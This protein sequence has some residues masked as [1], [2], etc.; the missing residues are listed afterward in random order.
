MNALLAWILLHRPDLEVDLVQ[1]KMNSG[2]HYYLLVTLPRSKIKFI[3]DIFSPVYVADYIM[4][5]H[6]KV[7]VLSIDEA[8][9]L[10]KWYQDYEKCSEEEL[11]FVSALIKK[12]LLSVEKINISDNQMLDDA[13]FVSS[14]VEPKIAQVRK[15]VMDLVEEVIKKEE[16]QGIYRVCLL[17]SYAK[18]QPSFDSVKG[19]ITPDEESDVDMQFYG[20][21]KALEK[22]ASIWNKEWAGWKKRPASLINLN[23]ELRL[24][25]VEDENTEITSALHGP[26]ILI[27][28]KKSSA[29][30]VDSYIRKT[31]N[32]IID[33][34]FSGQLLDQ[35]TNNGIPAFV[36]LLVRED[37]SALPDSLSLFKER[38]YLKNPDYI[39]LVVESA[40]RGIE[41]VATYRIAAL[42]WLMEEWFPKAP[43][44][45]NK[46]I[47]CLF[48]MT[49]HDE[50]IRIHNGKEIPR[51]KGAGS[52]LMAAI[53]EP[54][55]F[56][57]SDTAA[58]DIRLV[59]ESNLPRKGRYGDPD[60]FYLRIGMDPMNTHCPWLKKFS[61][62][63]MFYATYFTW[64]QGKMKK[65]IEEV[66][67]KYSF[68]STKRTEEESLVLRDKARKISVSSPARQIQ[69]SLAWLSQ[70]LQPRRARSRSNLR[71]GRIVLSFRLQVS[72]R[73]FGSMQPAACSLEPKSSA[74]P[75]IKKSPS[76]ELYYEGLKHDMEWLNRNVDVG[77]KVIDLGAGSGEFLRHLL[78]SGNIKKAVW[79]DKDFRYFVKAQKILND[80][81]LSFTPRRIEAAPLFYKNEFN[82]A[83]KRGVVHHL[84]DPLLG[85]ICA[86][87]ILNKNGRLIIMD[88]LASE[89]QVVNDFILGFNKQRSHDDM[90]YYTRPQFEEMLLKA[91]FEIEKIGT[92]A[93]DLNITE[94]LGEC[95]F[96]N[97]VEEYL[98]KANSEIKEAVKFREK[99]DS[100]IITLTDIMIIAKKK[101][102]SPLTNIPDCINELIIKFRLAGLSNKERIKEIDYYMDKY[103]RD[104]SVDELTPEIRNKAGV[105]AGFF[106][107]H[108]IFDKRKQGLIAAGAQAVFIEEPR[109]KIKPYARPRKTNTARNLSIKSESE[110][111]PLLY[112]DQKELIEKLLTGKGVSLLIASEDLMLVPVLSGLWKEAA[113]RGLKRKVLEI[114]EI[115]K[116]II[117]NAYKTKN[118]IGKITNRYWLGEIDEIILGYIEE[119]KDREEIIIRDEAIAS[120]ITTEALIEKIIARYGA[121]FFRKK[122]KLIASDIT[123]YFYIV[124]DIEG[125]IAVYDAFGRILQIRP[126]PM[127]IL[128]INV[129]RGNGAIFP[130]LEDMPQKI[131]T[132][133]RRAFDAAGGYGSII[134]NEHISTRRA[135]VPG[136]SELINSYPKNIILA[137]EDAFKTIPQKANIIRCFNLLIP[138]EYF[139]NIGQN[140][141]ILLGN[142]AEGGYLLVGYVDPY[143]SYMA[144]KKS[145]NKYKIKFSKGNY[146]DFL[147]ERGG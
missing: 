28:R 37:M 103:I 77:G 14:P 29:S 65:Y 67:E 144:Y 32:I 102:S 19:R 56:F 50:K 91:G 136:L 116:S 60:R 87:K 30:P 146:D 39:N 98:H 76:D 11:E 16:L 23:F 117:R 42:S 40:C 17:G 134:E 82:L 75:I 121:K 95:R 58:S 38:I 128:G 113:G 73:K 111:Y 112:S 15:A 118:E 123:I 140:I 125:N 114:E 45:D 44:L 93:Y 3:V 31:K 124:K 34:I 100:I 90:A 104:A 10:S 12:D 105:I 74:S 79:L 48:I 81:R 4:S 127:H 78:R 35:K 66:K 143:K 96:K 13:S 1:K 129:I 33:S 49:R 107:K 64:N 86:S 55:L 51:F 80:S 54:I 88:D 142:L 106:E 94:L 132:I 20:R 52:L 7:L 145:G 72:S 36:R 84:A 97:R 89:S 126:N 135:I 41:G 141:H 57:S 2:I 9:R 137:Q 119:F 110:Y 26:I 115:I 131:E 92:H 8:A 68:T 133:F 24:E 6:I 147:K 21:N 59:L 101:A 63:R 130:Q 109:K 18:D 47:E 83:I 5:G 138:N 69:E 99:E 22:I 120:G 61:F 108:Q 139:K 46:I 25:I 70:W 122:I 71:F 85:F 43:I 62:L 27:W 53:T